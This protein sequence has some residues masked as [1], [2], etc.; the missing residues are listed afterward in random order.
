MA[1]S[2][3]VL[4]APS[5]VGS[6]DPSTHIQPLTN[7]HDSNSWQS[8]L[9]SVGTCTSTCTYITQFTHKQNKTLLKE[10]KSAHR[11]TIKFASLSL[12]NYPISKGR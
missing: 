3:R 6:S 1:Q 10:E 9:I 11:S 12:N 5:K 4:T 8:L 7:D 2:L